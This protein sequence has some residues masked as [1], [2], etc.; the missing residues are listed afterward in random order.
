MRFFSCLVIISFLFTAYSGYSQVPDASQ[1]NLSRNDALQN[2]RVGRD[3]EARNRMNE[4]RVYYNEA[5]RICNT[6]LI[7]NPSNMDSYAVL[8]WTLQRQGKYNDVISWGERGLRVNANDYRIIETMGE[9]YFYLNNYVES[10]RFMQ[11]YVNSMPQGERASVAYFFIGEIFR[12]ERK[13]RH[14]DIAY[15]TA[16]RLDSGPALWWYRLGS[17]RESIGD[18]VPAV[19]AYERAL[20]LNPN[21]PEAREGLAR[22]RNSSG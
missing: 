9:A 4:A 8:T 13:F 6:E 3:L 19:E 2:Y 20:R 15:T 10:L 11:R 17:V 1:P 22:V 18:A 5:V 7:G 12:L 14:A 16:L 21:Y